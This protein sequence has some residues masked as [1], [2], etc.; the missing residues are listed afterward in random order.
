MSERE[1][2]LEQCSGGLGRKRRAARQ[3][4]GRGDAVSERRRDVI[5]R[6]DHNPSRVR[7]NSS[8]SITPWLAPT[9]RGLGG[10]AIEKDP[11]LLGRL[12]LY[13]TLGSLKTPSCM[14]LVLGALIRSKT[15]SSPQLTQGWPCATSELSVHKDKEG[16]VDLSRTSHRSQKLKTTGS[17]S[18]LCVCTCFSIRVLIHSL[19]R[20]SPSAHASK[21]SAPGQLTQGW[22][23]G[24]KEPRAWAPVTH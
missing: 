4:P 17:G 18:P 15:R 10:A 13:E 9:L 20:T 19:A 12:Q 11:V 16:M 1:H 21:S 5:E 8:L 3:R 23:C 7:L 6:P 14:C 24:A 22:P 2:H